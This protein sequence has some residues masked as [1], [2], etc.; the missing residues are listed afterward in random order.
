MAAVDVSSPAG[1]KAFNTQLEDKSYVNDYIITT[2][3][4]AVFGQFKE[5]PYAKTH[6]NASRW[7]RHIASYSEEERA[8]VSSAPVAAA[9]A[10]AAPAAKEE[11]A[12]DE[13]DCFGDETPED[14]ARQA[15]IQR[16]ADERKKMK[17]ASGKQVVEKSVVIL[18]VKPWDA[19][20]DLDA[21]DAQIR[22][23]TM[24]GLEWKTSEK[25][26][27]AYGV[28]KLVIMC[29]IVDKLVSVDDLQEK[30]GELEDHVQSTD[31]AAFSKL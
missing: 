27:I 2:E 12:E 29:H 6:P 3:D 20:T 10:A 23:I 5:A 16:I 31:V 17:E 11:E 19:E 14:E 15:E 30:I 18:E 25:K 4:F 21:L 7:Y 1:L 24:E 22:E 26:P 8:S 28:S 9:P 13:F